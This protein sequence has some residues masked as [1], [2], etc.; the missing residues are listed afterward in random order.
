MATSAIVLK[1]NA[2][3]V[4]TLLSKNQ[5]TKVHGFLQEKKKE[6]IT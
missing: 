5:N 3:H 1:H 6:Q 4:T 2:N